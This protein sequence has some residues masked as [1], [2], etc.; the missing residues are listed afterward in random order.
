MQV[1][2]G[3]AAFASAVSKEAIGYADYYAVICFM[4]VAGLATCRAVLLTPTDVPIQTAK[5]VEDMV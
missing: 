2:T 5:I 1:T 4:V 3:S